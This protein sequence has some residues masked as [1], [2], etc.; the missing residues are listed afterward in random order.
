MEKPK[1]KRRTKAEMEAARAKE[2]LAPSVKKRKRR[3]KAQM[4]RARAKEA[5]AQAE[6]DFKIP[7]NAQSN[8]FSKVYDRPQKSDKPFVPSKKYPIPKPLPKYEERS[9]DKITD[10]LVMSGGAKYGFTKRKHLISWSTLSKDWSVLYDCRYN[11]T[12]KLY[13]SF[14][15]LN[16]KKSDVTPK[17]SKRKGKS[18]GKPRNLRKKQL[19]MVR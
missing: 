6:K 4:E 8:S 18:N 13:K 12:E 15:N 19:Q 10:V 14:Q 3:T 9:G 7:Q 1:R 16:T 2:A 11:D 17:P 5:K